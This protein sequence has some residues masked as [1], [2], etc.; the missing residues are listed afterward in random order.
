MSTVKTAISI[1]D[2]VFHEV[3][4][5]AKELHV[6]RSEIFSKAVQEF[7]EKQKNIKT[8]KTLNKVYTQESTEEENKFHRQALKRSLKV[9]DEW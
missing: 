4:N 2:G 5:L 9:I 3:E 6:S 1:Q 7:I 8:L